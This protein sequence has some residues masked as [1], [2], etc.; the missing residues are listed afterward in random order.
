MAKKTKS[1]RSNAKPRKTAKKT[2]KQIQKKTTPSDPKKLAELEKYEREIKKGI[3]EYYK[4]GALLQ[5]IRDEKLYKHGGYKT[6]SEYCGKVFNFGR[7]YGYRLIAYCRVWN[8]INENGKEK[9]PERV[10]R[11]LTTL[12]TEEEIRECWK[13][14]KE[15]AGKDL[16]RY[17]EIEA[18]VNEKKRLRL[19]EAKHFD[20][21]QNKGMMF[22]TSLRSSVSKKD[23]AAGII[24]S[25]GP[26]FRKIY[27]SIKEAKK[28]GVSFTE[29]DEK[30]LRNALIKTLDSV[31]EN[32]D[33]EE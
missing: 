5:K 7:A 12:K 2:G 33:T 10:I 1:N 25:S 4:T 11:S 24:E 32:S 17:T 9:I 22:F 26:S 30:K 20:P 8:L 27:N 13:E 28:Q 23:I 16:P 29:A 15:K 14:A 3:I 31:F 19:M 6:F 18:L 21:Q